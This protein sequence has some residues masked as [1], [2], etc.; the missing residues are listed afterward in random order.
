MNLE[1]LFESVLQMSEPCSEVWTTPEGFKV[2]FSDDEFNGKCLTYLR[3]KSN[4]ST[5]IKLDEALAIYHAIQ[6]FK[7]DDE[8]QFFE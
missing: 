4:S 5:T 1:K 2:Y 3:P 8:S 7:K 6:Y